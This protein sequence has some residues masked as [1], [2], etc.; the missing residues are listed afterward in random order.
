MKLRRRLE[1]LEAKIEP[2]KRWCPE[3]GGGGKPRFVFIRPGEAYTPGGCPTCG[4]GP[5]WVLTVKDPPKE[6][7][8]LAL[9]QGADLGRTP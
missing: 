3:C 1:R 4:E 9:P 8:H 2:A 7:A 5:L 6:F